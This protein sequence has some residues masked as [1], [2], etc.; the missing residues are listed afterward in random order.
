MCGKD[1]EDHAIKRR[2]FIV[3]GALTVAGAGVCMC[4]LNGC[5]TITGVGDTP[6]VDKD[7]YIIE[8]VPELKIVVSLDRIPELSEIGGAVKIVD[9]ALGDNLIIA[10]TR[11][12]EYVT[13]SLHCTHRGVELEYDH[14]RK[15]FK[16][17]SAGGSK[18]TL[19]GKNTGGPAD[20]PLTIYSNLIEG[21]TLIISVD[22]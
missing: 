13:A 15:L 20:R 14:E 3:G 2:E 6:P 21:E 1:R 16:C 5:S 7:S 8:K 18:F 12:K 10:R 19:D 9:D 22:E 17:S 4:G 11:D